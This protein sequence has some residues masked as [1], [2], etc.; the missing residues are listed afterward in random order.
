MIRRPAMMTLHYWSAKRI[1]ILIGF[2]LTILGSLG[3][4][5]YV[6]PLQNRSAAFDQQSKDTTS[7]IDTLKNAQAQYLL[8]RE[9]TALVFAIN[10]EGP[11]PGDAS[12]HSPLSNLYQLSLLDRSNAVRIMIGELAMAKI[13]DFATTRTRYN[14][15]I[16]AARKNVALDTYTAVDDFERARMDQA[17]G[18]MGDLQQTYLALGQAKA[19]T[20]R[21]V[22]Q[23]QTSLLALMAL[24]STFLLAANLLSTRPEKTTAAAANESSANADDRVTELTTAAQLI[25]IALERA[26]TISPA[27]TPPR[28]S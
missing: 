22:D 23:R 4:H 3:Q 2:G 20:D 13:V 26:R 11:A 21:E 16:D 12:A 8:F 6:D 15:L 25:E 17:N 14:A 27:Q 24:G 7:K 1:A 5:F 18:L 28:G 19:E 10:A 9:Q